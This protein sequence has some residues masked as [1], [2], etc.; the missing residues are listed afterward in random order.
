MSEPRTRPPLPCTRPW[1]G[2]ITLIAV[3]AEVDLLLSLFSPPWECG[4]GEF[5]IVFERT[6]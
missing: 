1:S 4:G 5:V 6:L 2:T 3:V